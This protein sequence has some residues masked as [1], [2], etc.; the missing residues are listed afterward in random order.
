MYKTWD[1]LRDKLFHCGQQFPHFRTNFLYMFTEGWR[2]PETRYSW[3]LLWIIRYTNMAI[4]R[5][6]T[7]SNTIFK[8]RGVFIK[9]IVYLYVLVNW[10]FAFVIPKY[11][12][13]YARV[14]DKTLFRPYKSWD[15]ELHRNLNP[16][17]IK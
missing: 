13:K 4:W 14:V 12:T 15:S 3:F 6:K 5:K 10:Q 16:V 8:K 11:K 1:Q 9:S 2:N 7:T 17:Y